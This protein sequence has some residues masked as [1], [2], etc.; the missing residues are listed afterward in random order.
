MFQVK[1]SKKC[2]PKNAIFLWLSTSFLTTFIFAKGIL[3]FHMIVKAQGHLAKD[4]SKLF[5]MYYFWDNLQIKFLK[6][7][8]WSPGV[9]FYWN[10]QPIKSDEENRF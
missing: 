4:N 5:D 8:S 3:I 1:W 10:Y 7:D 2:S 9:G 6:L